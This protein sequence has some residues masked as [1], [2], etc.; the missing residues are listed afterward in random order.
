MM[1]TWR[2]E[3][4]FLLQFLLFICLRLEALMITNSWLPN[5]LPSRRY[6][7][8]LFFILILIS[9]WKFFVSLFIYQ[10]ALLNNI[11]RLLLIVN[12]YV[13]SLRSSLILDLGHPGKSYIR[14]P[15]FLDVLSGPPK[16]LHGFFIE[17]FWMRSL[18]N[19]LLFSL[20]LALQILKLLL[21]FLQVFQDDF[22]V[23]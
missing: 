7:V 15:L 6:L 10:F 19:W 14:D 9:G 1:R 13:I 8:A 2:R 4:W 12:S 20:S 18:V 21:F 17:F 23:R 5:I 16:I 3:Q 22:H 11:E